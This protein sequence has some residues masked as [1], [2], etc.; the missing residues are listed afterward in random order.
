MEQFWLSD[1]IIE[2]IKDINYRKLT[3]EQELIK[4]K[5]ESKE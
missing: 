1:D 3:E 4:L 5:E 2:Q